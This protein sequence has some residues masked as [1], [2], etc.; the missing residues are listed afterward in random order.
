MSFFLF[1][2]IA[3]ALACRS[4]GHRVKPF[5][6]ETQTSPTNL[7]FAWY[8]GAGDPSPTV[9]S[10]GIQVCLIWEI[11]QKLSQTGDS[12]GSQGPV[13]SKFQVIRRFVSV[14][15]WSE[16][17]AFQSGVSRFPQPRC[18]A[19]SCASK[20][21]KPSVF[22]ASATSRSIGCAGRSGEPVPVLHCGSGGPVSR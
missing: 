15:L 8:G 22:S 7:M 3:N 5:R 21:Q 2:R 13:A 1:V 4:H 14:A 6:S 17:S 10:K 16:L 11:R 19:S 12:N 18:P 9:E 20:P